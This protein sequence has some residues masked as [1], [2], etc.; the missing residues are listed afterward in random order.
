M[1]SIGTYFGALFILQNYLGIFSGPVTNIKPQ[2]ANKPRQN[3]QIAWKKRRYYVFWAKFQPQHRGLSSTYLHLDLILEAVSLG[4]LGQEQPLH[5]S[6]ESAI[7]HQES[8][9]MHSYL[10]SAFP[11]APSPLPGRETR[12]RC[13]GLTVKPSSRPQPLLV[14]LPSPF[15]G[16]GK[17]HMGNGSCGSRGECGHPLSPFPHF[18]FQEQSSR[19]LWPDWLWPKKISIWKGEDSTTQ[20][21]S[22]LCFFTF[23]LNV[24][25]WAFSVA[26]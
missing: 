1:S 11:L 16:S 25:S 9:G 8:L 4:L 17:C 12:W 3:L 14:P 6:L 2:L 7:N 10:S 26:W 15:Q 21:S 5:R 24:L 19:N 23:H 20:T 22:P 13:A 18:S